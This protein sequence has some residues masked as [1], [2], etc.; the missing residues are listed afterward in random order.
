MMMK[1]SLGHNGVDLEETLNPMTNRVSLN[2]CMVVD[3]LIRNN[4]SWVC[5]HHHSPPCMVDYRDMTIKGCMHGQ[6]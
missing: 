5:G 6:Y 1:R 4:T 2:Y 3:N